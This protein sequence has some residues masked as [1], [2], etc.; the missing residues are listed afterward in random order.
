[1]N[2][3]H[4]ISSSTSHTSPD[5]LR[6]CCRC[7]PLFYMVDCCMAYFHVL[8][9]FFLFYQRHVQSSLLHVLFVETISSPNI[10]HWINITPEYPRQPATHL[11]AIRGNVVFTPLCSTWLIVAWHIFMFCPS[12]S[13]CSIN[14]TYNLLCYMYYLSKLYP[15]PILFIG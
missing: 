8:S 9:Y 15:H 13:S 3:Y 6:H 14:V 7:T 1:V 4:R 2:N 12:T 5:N 11:L 10:I